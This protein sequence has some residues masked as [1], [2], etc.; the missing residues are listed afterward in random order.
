M[1]VSCGVPRNLNDHERTNDWDKRAPIAGDLYTR[2]CATHYFGRDSSARATQNGL[3][4]ILKP[5]DQLPIY[6]AGILRYPRCGKF[7]AF[8]FVLVFVRRY[9]EKTWYAPTNHKTALTAD[10]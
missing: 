10:T 3:T 6:V 1:H 9:L 5:S 4:N 8:M 7:Y 2:E